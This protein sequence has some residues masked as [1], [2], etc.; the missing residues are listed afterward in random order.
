MIAIVGLYKYLCDVFGYLG[1]N[2]DKGMTID[3]HFINA[4]TK[5]YAKKEILDKIASNV[6]K[7]AYSNETISD[8]DYIYVKT[9]VENI[10]KIPYNELSLKDKIKFK[11]IYNL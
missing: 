8:E 10:V 4:Y 11:Y 9:Q 6:K 1:V 3:E 7:V 5:G 2:K